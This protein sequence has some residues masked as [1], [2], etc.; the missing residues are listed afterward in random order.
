[1]AV[2]LDANNFGYFS[3]STSSPLLSEKDQKT[4]LALSII[5]GIFTF[6][7]GHLISS[8]VYAS[9]KKQ[10]SELLTIIEKTKGANGKGKN[11]ADLLNDFH[12]LQEHCLANYAP[13][14][15]INFKAQ[16]FAIETMPENHSL[17]EKIDAEDLHEGRL[18]P[19]D[20]IAQRFQQH[21][22]TL[23]SKIKKTSDIRFSTILANTP[24]GKQTLFALYKG[25]NVTSLGKGNFGG[26]K[27]AQ[28]LATGEWCAVKITREKINATDDYKPLRMKTPEQE[29][30][31]I[32]VAE[33]LKGNAYRVDQHN[34]I[35]YLFMNY[36]P[37]DPLNKIAQKNMNYRKLV[38]IAIGAL[39]SL[40]V[41]H[42]K[43]YLHRDLKSPNIIH[44]SD[45]SLPITARTNL[46]DYG[47][48]MPVD[49]NGEIIV[50]NSFGMTGAL[51]S[52][53]QADQKLHLSQYTDMF[54]MGNVFYDLMGSIL[55]Y[56]HKINELLS[57]IDEELQGKEDSENLDG[58]KGQKNEQLAKLN[59]IGSDAIRYDVYQI[60]K[61]M[62]PSWSEGEFSKLT[63]AEGL[64]EFQTIYQKYWGQEM[65]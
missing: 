37:G 16:T 58:L 59:E 36:L 9:Q 61:K 52:W 18:L 28:N 17:L 6:G 34:H 42:E 11:D 35:F 33:M 30:Q 13:S 62:S 41:F 7:I 55:N 57:V 29:L 31:G 44:N 1:M 45:S 46:I 48:A 19:Q 20:E 53:R 5:M 21:Q 50:E 38:E 22:S 27:L 23:Q 3:F 54:S 51:T 10:M 15:R 39:H 40:K 26:V 63:A 47:S 25:K 4:A 24:Q 49:S 12:D 60:I 65:S 2:H 56:K 43:G 32:K 8:F 64:A 14:F